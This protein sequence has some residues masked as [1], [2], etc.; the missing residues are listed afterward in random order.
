MSDV[1]VPTTAPAPGATSPAKAETVLQK[2]GSATNPTDPPR[3]GTTTATEPPKVAEKRK[4]KGKVDGQEREWELSDDDI[5]VRLQKS[6]AAERRM[7]EGAEIRKAA[8]QLVEDLRKDPFGVLSSPEIGIN[9]EELAEQRLIEKYKA[10]QMTEEQRRVYEL[11]QKL[12]ARDAEDK[13]RKDVEGQAKRQE[14]EK[15]VYAQ[16]EKRFME[17]AEKGGLPKNMRTLAM[18]AEVALVNHEYGIELSADQIAAEV[19]ERINQPLGV[20]RGL[21]GEAL[22]KELG[23]ETVKEVMSAQLALY[24]AKKTANQAPVPKAPPAPLAKEDDDESPFVKQRI[25][26]AEWR[27]WRRS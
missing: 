14:M 12:K 10:E 11:E 1:V 19:R 4:Y 26:L 24:R 21:K 3:T 9:L 16:E 27:K 23:E 15:Q 5:T 2:P 6:E 8:K 7:Q 18:M 20:V 17:A 13:R 25:S 22:L